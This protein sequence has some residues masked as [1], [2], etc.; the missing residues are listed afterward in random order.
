[1]RTIPEAAPMQLRPNRQLW[2]C[3]P[4]PIPAITRPGPSGTLVPVPMDQ[5]DTTDSGNRNSLCRA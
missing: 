5:R 4:H 1:M 3:I 2:V